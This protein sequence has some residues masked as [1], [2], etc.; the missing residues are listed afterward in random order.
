MIIAV[1]IVDKH[2]EPGNRHVGTYLFEIPYPA[3]E[4]SKQ[5]DLLAADYPEKS[6]ENLRPYLGK[7]LSKSDMD[8]AFGRNNKWQ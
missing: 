7:L 3:R 5:M 8:E 4:H 1:S 6:E 2:K